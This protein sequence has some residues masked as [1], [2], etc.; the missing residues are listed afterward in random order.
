MIDFLLG[1]C[2]GGALVYALNHFKGSSPP[3]APD[4]LLNLETRIKT[5]ISDAMTQALADLKATI[6]AKLAN[7][8]SE[9]IQSAVEAKDAEDT[10]AVKDFTATLA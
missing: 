7:G 2:V 3:K 5:M 6:D 8:S 9:A 4:F 1:I 10:Q